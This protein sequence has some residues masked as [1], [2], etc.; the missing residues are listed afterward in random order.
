ME[1]NT[2]LKL[3]KCACIAGGEWH[4]LGD[5][6]RAEYM[7][8]SEADWNRFREQIKKYRENGGFQKWAEVKQTLPNKAYPKS[9]IA[10]YI[11]DNYTKYTQSLGS[12]TTDRRDIMKVKGIYKMCSVKIGK[13]ASPPR[14]A[15]FF[16]LFIVNSFYL[17][18]H[19]NT[20][21]ML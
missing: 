4:N 19:G 13:R 14:R 6:Q 20:Q 10:I 9:P 3:T 16:Q 18:L 2:D 7:K 1:K 11:R 5:G 12:T 15:K 21:G 8:E 17:V